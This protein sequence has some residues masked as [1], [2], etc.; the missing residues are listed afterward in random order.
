MPNFLKEAGAVSRWCNYTR[1]IVFLA[2]VRP[3]EQIVEVSFS[4]ES[5]PDFAS[6]CSFC[7]NLLYVRDLK[8]LSIVARFQTRMFTHF[9]HLS[10]KC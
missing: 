6:H 5:K 10:D 1:V 4:I 8:G 2:K 3:I 7:N 9:N